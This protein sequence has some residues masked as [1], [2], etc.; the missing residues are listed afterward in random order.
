MAAQNNDKNQSEDIFSIQDFAYLCLARWKWFL[1]SVII[2]LAI[3]MAYLLTTPPIYQRSASVLIKEDSKGQSINSD[4]TS[5]FNNLGLSQ[6]Q[7]N[8]NNELIAI[9][10]PAVILETVKRLSLDVDCKVKGTFHKETLYG[11][12]LPVKIEF[13]SLKDNASAAMTVNI[14]K[15]GDIELSDF[16]CGGTKDHDKIVRGKLNEPMATPLGKVTLKPADGYTAYMKGR[17]PTIHV[18][19]TSLYG[20]TDGLKNAIKADISDKKATVIDLSYNDEVPQRAE[21]VLNTL[22]NVYKETWMK[23]KN[24]MT[25]STSLF[26]TERLGV[27]ER[28][29]GD[30]DQNISSYK[31]QHLLPDVEAASNLYM[32]QS[33]ETSNMILELN[34]RLSMARYIRNYLSGGAGKN[35]L[36]PVNSGIENSGIEAQ[37]TQYNTTQL[38]RNN[39][40]ANSSESNP[41]VA[42]YDQSLA[43]MRK[44]IIS[45]I[46]NLVVTL[47]TQIANLQQNEQK[48]TA[49]IAANP[50]Q[51]KYL[52]AVGRQQKVKESLYLFL[53]QKREE[54]ELSQAFTAY[55]TRV[56]AP[57]SGSMI[58]TSPV[59]RKILL[60]AFAIGLA[61]PAAI[62]YMREQMNSTIRGKS[63]LKSLTMPFIGEIPLYVKRK[64]SRLSRFRK[65]EASEAQTVVV[66]EGSRNLIN[67]AFRVLRT[68]LEFMSGSGDKSN[69][70][71]ITSFN[72]GSGKSFLTVNMGV[73]LAIKGKKVLVIDGDLRHGSASQYVGSP[74]IGF[75]DYLGKKTND[76]DSI[77]VTDE[78]HPNLSMLPIGTIPPNPT[79]L[80]VSGRLEKVIAAARELFD[81]VLIDCPPI[82]LVA[83]TQIIEKLA[84]RT[85][86]VVRAGLLERSM[87]SELQNIYEQKKFKNMSV[88]LNGTEGSRGR[89]G[90]KYGYRYG[91]HYG[92]GYGY[93][94]GYHYGSDKKE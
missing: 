88:V 1:L 13:H 33:K 41:L 85:V 49:Q 2:A 83:D 94:Y 70:I 14:S 22:I 53:L 19:R 40:I 3:G 64:R 87:V 44:A 81:Y 20:K 25:I 59:S 76:M 6:G 66:K 82:E 32:N 23:D 52:S 43:S 86:F 78:N 4:V 68:N 57:P 69:V 21:D 48:T 90:Y 89:Y 16:V 28:E 46:D 11:S 61:I 26:I 38:Q 15:N 93:H 8:V 72:P 5:M 37:I 45:S 50:N 71:V 31:S 73:A 54:N 79:E 12:T 47:N 92:Y 10:S 62:I 51:A 29:L 42:D 36:L 77:I 34:T 9:K 24:E 84:D 58:P 7:T 67:E 65:K 18:T 35:Q 75:S 60:I 30:V 17:R 27:I 56:I 80:L 91:Y 39:L 55:N 74:K 63:D